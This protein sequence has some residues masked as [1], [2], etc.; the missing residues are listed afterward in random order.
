MTEYFL[1]KEYNTIAFTK[2]E[3]NHKEFESCTFINCNFSSCHFIAVTFIECHFKNCDLSQC[4]VNHVGLRTVYFTDCKI[5][6]VNFAMCDQ[7]IFEINFENCLLDFSKFYG[8]SLKGT[9]FIGCSLVAN[10]FMGST[11]TNVAFQNCDLY[12]TVFDKAIANKVDF[13][14][15]YNYTINP[16]KT[17]LNKS[18]FSLDEVKGLLIKHDIIII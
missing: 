3:L 11:L 14:T 16:S 7:F 9:Q 15:S 5:E 6:G 13:R 18:H 2:E 1:D 10:D 17:K 4:A 12:K 8:L